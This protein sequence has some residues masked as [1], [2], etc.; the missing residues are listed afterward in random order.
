MV[1]QV[2]RELLASG[3]DRLAD[4]IRVHDRPAGP[5]SA[6]S[7]VEQGHL[8][9]AAAG[10][11]HWLATVRARAPELL[12]G[13]GLHVGTPAAARPVAPPRRLPRPEGGDAPAPATEP[14]LV[15]P[16]A[17]AFVEQPRSVA[18]PTATFPVSAGRRPAHPGT[19]GDQPARGPAPVRILRWLH[20]HAGRPVA[21]AAP[22]TPAL[23]R[24][25][26]SGDEAGEAAPGPR[27]RP[28]SP[29]GRGGPAPDA[30]PGAPRPPRPEMPSQDPAPSVH[31]RPGPQFEDR[32][33][34]PE[35]PG[36]HPVWPALPEAARTPGAA[37][38]D[39]VPR[40]EP[41]HAVFPDRPR[42]VADDPGHEQAP[43]EAA[44][45]WP[46][47]PDEG[48]GLEPPRSVFTDAWVR[49]LDDE[50]RCG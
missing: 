44:G 33:G 49:D 24:A 17:P 37:R 50:Q 42:A 6:L 29:V 8:S 11:E 45:P 19:T 38:F 3:L 10:N 43:G 36:R 16:D 40:R 20:R 41:A 30:R 15:A 2:L 12:T 4:A 39:A 27:P 1:A 22:E 48:D 18:P 35:A 14:Q 28:T 26:A 31:R 25:P 32:P 9:A 7:A 34:S 5:P 47:L 21:P 13:G 23:R 46:E